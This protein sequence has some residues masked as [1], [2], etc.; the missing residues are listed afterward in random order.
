MPDQATAPTAPARGLLTALLLGAL[1]ALTGLG[2]RGIW[3]PDEGRYTNVA[4]QMLATGDYVHP[5]RHHETGH[6]TKPPLTYWAIAASMAGFGPKPWA[7][8]VPAVLAFLASIALVYAI[9][10]VLLPGHERLAAVVYATSFLPFG[11][12]QL[13]TTD[14]LLAAA[15]TLAVYGWVRA[16]FAADGRARAWI[17]LMW[18]GFGLGFLT[19][20]PPA[21]LP[22]AAILAFHWTSDPARRVPVLDP[23]GLLLFAVVALPWYAVVIVDEPRLFDYFIGKEVVARVA[24]AEHGRNPEWYGWIVV[25]G[26]TLVIGTLPWTRDALRALAGHVRALAARWRERLVP[27]RAEALWFLMLWFWLPLIVF[28]IARSRLPLYLL[29]LFAPLAILIADARLARGRS[30][31]ALPWLLAW[32]SMLL[33][34]NAL[35]ARMPTHKDA[36]RWAEHFR[37]YVYA[38]VREV[39]F[40]DDMARY[41]LHLETGAEVEKLSLDPLPQPAINP[42]VDMDL[43]TE[44]AESEPDRLW[45]TKRERFAEVDRRIRALGF[46]T[47]PAAPDYRGR[48]IFRVTPAAPQRP[49]DADRP[50]DASTEPG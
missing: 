9:A 1:V 16:R 24:S 35:V 7:A 42:E 10:R 41:G 29:P 11:A 12:S 2:W 3:D 45:I 32:A 26:P 36:S 15:L 20:G 18:A 40:V 8:R 6:W 47:E 31:P 48:A 17:A 14:Y 25:Y 39:V 4:M 5:H 33:A 34:V 28:C 49:A 43:A 46:V 21:L 22:L 27:G 50:R 44:L 19:K 37:S 38:P 30:V 23:R 13:I